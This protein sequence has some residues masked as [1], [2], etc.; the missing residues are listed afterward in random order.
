MYIIIK[1]ERGIV[2]NINYDEY[3]KYIEEIKT[4][5]E[6]EE[7]E[8]SI[9]SLDESPDKTSLLLKIAMKKVEIG[10]TPKIE[11]TKKVEK[12]RLTKTEKGL[13]I[14]IACGSAALITLASAVALDKKNSTTMAEATIESTIDE[15]ANVMDTTSATEATTEVTEAAMEATS[16]YETNNDS[17]VSSTATSTQ[18]V[19]EDAEQQRNEYLSDDTAASAVPTYSS[20]YLGHTDLYNSLS[21]KEKN[22]M[23]NYPMYAGAIVKYS[24]DYGA[25]LSTAIKDFIDNKYVIPYPY[26]CASIGNYVVNKPYDEDLYNSESGVKPIHPELYGDSLSEF[27]QLNDNQ[28][29]TANLNCYIIPALI[30]YSQNPNTSCSLDQA[31]A[32]WCNDWIYVDSNTAFGD[33]VPIITSDGYS[34]T[35]ENGNILYPYDYIGDDG[36][37]GIDMNAG[38]GA[39]EADDIYDYTIDSTE[40]FTR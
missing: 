12:K 11:T 30:L 28:R 6:L 29:K 37:S 23:N 13:I 24:Q 32:D 31:I 3:V 14:A 4:D 5:E 38:M 34:Y 21:N 35:D 10:Y 27:Y 9:N 8:K 25:D 33:E 18:S 20:V 7:L 19:E 26:G 40:G 1:Q 22:F 39:G 36:I 2:M 15:S 16:V 17:K